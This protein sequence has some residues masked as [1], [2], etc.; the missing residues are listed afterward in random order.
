MACKFVTFAVPLRQSKTILV[1]VNP[2]D[3]LY[4]LQNSFQDS[5][6]VL[7]A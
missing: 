1:T 7:V 4:A 6:R 5:C 3:A 2:A